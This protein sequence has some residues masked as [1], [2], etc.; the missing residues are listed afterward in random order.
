M[1]R[2]T[3]LSLP[4]SLSLLPVLLLAVPTNGRVGLWRKDFS[5]ATILIST[6]DLPFAYQ[7]LLGYYLLQRLSNVDGLLVSQVWWVWGGVGLSLVTEPDREAV[8]LIRTLDDS[9]IVLVDQFRTIRKQAI[10][11][12]EIWRREEP[13]SLLWRARLAA[14]H[15]SPLE[16]EVKRAKEV[17]L[18]SFEK[19]LKG[20]NRRPVVLVTRQGNRLRIVRADRFPHGRNLSY[21]HTIR[22]QTQEANQVHWLAWAPTS[23]RPEIGLIVGCFVGNGLT[24]FFVGPFR[25]TDPL[26][27]DVRADWNLHPVGGEIYIY[28]AGRPDRFS[29]LRKKAYERLAALRKVP[30]SEHGLK[31][32][33]ERAIHRLRLSLSD[34]LEEGRWLSVWLAAGHTEQDFLSLDQAIE[35]IT[36]DDLLRALTFLP[37]VWTEVTDGR[38]TYAS[39][40]AGRGA[41]GPAGD[42][43]Q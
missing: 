5:V 6:H 24:S 9:D 31:G 17:T 40:V 7:V 36:A 14:F 16:A 10:R 32:V 2:A 19:A 43:H 39:T 29:S 12:M 26:A 42:T 11:Q 18:D 20:L 37:L 30:L 13:T 27:Y 38:W 33:R 22:S 28:L 35:G 4:I 3:P 23:F 1:K 15:R 34:P 25:E 21:G 8:S 41:E